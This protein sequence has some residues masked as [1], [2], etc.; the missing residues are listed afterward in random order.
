MK[1]FTRWIL[2]LITLLSLLLITAC[3]S[4]SQEMTK[5][6]PASV[7][8]GDGEFNKVTLTEKAAERLDIQSEPVR[9][10]NMGGETNMVI[11]YA[12]IIYGLNGETW[13]YIRNPGAESL[14]FVRVPITI[15]RIED[16]L[17]ILKDGP[18]VGT[19][20]VTVG[21]AELYGTDTGVGK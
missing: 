3:G 10:E 9:E 17:V 18:E 6:E 14:T 13:A 5:E 15:D 12:A 2:I 20:V 8:E 11:P 19:E 7:E 1:H 16:D 21:V 4:D